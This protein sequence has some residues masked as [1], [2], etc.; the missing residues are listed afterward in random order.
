[1]F[2]EVTVLKPPPAPLYNKLQ[3]IMWDFEVSYKDGD[4]LAPGAIGLNGTQVLLGTEFADAPYI[5]SW[6]ESFR[7]WHNDREVTSGKAPLT[8]ALG[9]K[10]GESVIDATMGLGKD[11]CQLLAAGAKVL[12]FE[13]VPEVFF[14]GRVSQ[15]FEDFLPQQLQLFFG[16]V[17]DNPSGL[18]I[19]FDPMFDD[20]SKRK[21][22][23]HKGMGAFHL[24]VGADDDAGEEALRLRGL[25]Q[26]L[27][28]KRPSKKK[29]LLENI[30]S[31]WKG[32]AISY[33]LYL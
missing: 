12:A 9:L 20:G 30:N 33:D 27:V 22:K 24:L 17:K 32:K 29:A 31:T 18:P 14:L 5:Y 4:Q 2:I 21:A 1:M 13:R 11:S 3:Q 7:S 8:K 6:E 15:V 10:K 16:E 25:T 26:R 28:I 19:Y 23:A